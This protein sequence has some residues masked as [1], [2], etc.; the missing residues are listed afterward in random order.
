MSAGGDYPDNWS[1]IT[2][3]IKEQAG[4][5]CEH[6]SHPHDPRSGRAL[7]VHHLDG[8]PANCT[9]ENLVALCQKCHLH[10]QATYRPGQLVMGFAVRGWMTKRGLP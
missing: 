9:P 10:L 6:C 7:T 4:W 8:D 3:A 1:E 2:Q 5:R